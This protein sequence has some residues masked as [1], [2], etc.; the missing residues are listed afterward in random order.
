M[1]VDCMYQYVCMYNVCSSVWMHV[2]ITSVPQLVGQNENFPTVQRVQDMQV[3]R[4]KSHSVVL[5]CQE[6]LGKIGCGSI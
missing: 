2:P 5:Q 6:D 1:Y 4:G 3:S